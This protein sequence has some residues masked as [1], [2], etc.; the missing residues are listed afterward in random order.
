MSFTLDFIFLILTIVVPGLLFQRFYY[1]G[2]FSK[3]FNTKGSIYK[4]I[5][6][7]VI[8]GIL[9]QLLAVFCYVSFRD[10]VLSNTD[11][12]KIFLE[13]SNPLNLKSDIS[14]ITRIFIDEDILMVMSH[15]F[16]VYF[17]A[18]LFGFIFSRLIRLIHFDKKFKLFRYKNQWYYIFSG[19]IFLFKKFKNAPKILGNV[20][21]EYSQET[22][23]PPY[24]DILLN[25]NGVSSLF[26]SGYIVDYDLDVDNISKLDKLYLLGAHRYRAKRGDECIEVRDNK[27]KVKVSIPGDVFVLSADKILNLNLTFIPNPTK[28]EEK[29]NKVESRRERKQKILNNIYVFGSFLKLLILSYLVFINTSFFKGV[30]PILSGYF[31]NTTY[32]QK[33]LIILIVL[34]VVSIFFPEE[35]II[36]NKKENSANNKRIYEFSVKNTFEK[37]IFLVICYVIYGLIYSFYFSL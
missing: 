10:R 25:N 19:E 17:L 24:A 9:V 34:Q 15:L 30:S 32:F 28:L 37:V 27:S 20:K 14:E 36:N 13:L 5:F 21:G 23:Y 11:V 22:F 8:P 26:Y 35:I 7:S 16:V 3:Q 2:E 33:G 4:S 18:I 31:N 1:F 29:K 12:L 6:F